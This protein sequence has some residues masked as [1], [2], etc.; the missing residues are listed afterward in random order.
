MLKNTASSQYFSIHY[1]FTQ[2]TSK[3]T[4]S[5]QQGSNTLTR[6]PGAGPLDRAVFPQSRRQSPVPSPGAPQ[7]GH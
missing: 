3:P 2:V 5:C 7:R 6:Q 1:K 4:A